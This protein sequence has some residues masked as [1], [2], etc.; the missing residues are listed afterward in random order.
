MDI[1]DIFLDI[2]LKPPQPLMGLFFKWAKRE[3]LW[4]NRCLEL[5]QTLFET[6]LYQFRKVECI[7]K[8]FV[9][10]NVWKKSA[11]GLVTASKIVFCKEIL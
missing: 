4:V 8:F 6:V 1:F 3:I 7:L 5:A 9:E 2:L 10:D 11:A